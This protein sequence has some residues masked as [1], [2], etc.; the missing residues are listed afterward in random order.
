M[1]MDKRVHIKICATHYDWI[2]EQAHKYNKSMGAFIRDTIM[3]AYMEDK[4]YEWGQEERNSK[5]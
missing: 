1:T 4:S 2:K 5:S 3:I